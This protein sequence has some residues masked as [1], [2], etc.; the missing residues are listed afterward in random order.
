MPSTP[1][2]WN[3]EWLNANSQRKFPLRDDASAKDVSGT[4][5]LPTD[6]LV[7]LL[8]PVHADPSIDPTLLH[9]LTVSIFGGGVTISFGYDGVEVGSIQV[10]ESAFQPN[11]QRRIL[12]TGVFFDTIA[13]VVI[14][15]LDSIKKFAGSYTFDIAGA[16]L[17]PRVVV[18]TLRGVSAI[19]LKNNEDISQAI[20]G[21]IVLQAGRN[22]ALAFQENAGTALDP[23]VITFSA[24]EGEGLND[25][26]ACSEATVLPC[27]KTIDG[28]EPDELG[29]FKLLEGECVKLDAI[30]NGLKLIDDCATP[31]C[32][33]QELEVVLSALERISGQV[34]AL[35]QLASQMQGQI[36]NLEANIIASNIGSMPPP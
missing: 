9:I 11:L 3:I 15:S 21:D 16:G 7:D 33:C 14:G 28:I 24:I 23:H 17:Q 27:I 19:F 35:N 18:P 29:D 26:C 5:T 6:F 34:N 8:W 4:L 10:D 32:G 1:Y 22:F 25:P 31:C 13:T 30:A 20:Q 2:L 36:G 12:G